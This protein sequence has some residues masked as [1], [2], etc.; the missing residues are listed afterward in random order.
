MVVKANEA[1]R[2]PLSPST[3]PKLA[4][5]ISQL[6]AFSF[7]ILAAIA[8]SYLHSWKQWV[9]TS[10]FALIAIAAEFFSIFTLRRR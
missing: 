3:Q 7:G 6:I 10:I 9:L 5:A 1:V 8:G 2:N 4:V